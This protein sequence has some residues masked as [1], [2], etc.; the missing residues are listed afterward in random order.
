[1]PRIGRQRLDIAPLAFGVDRIEGER[2]LARPADAGDDD[3]LAD[4]ERDVDVLEVMRARAADNEIGGGSN[5][6]LRDGI[7]HAYCALFR[8]RRKPAS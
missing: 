6:P 3:Q 2:R 7:G 1:L 5:S 4:R 8:G